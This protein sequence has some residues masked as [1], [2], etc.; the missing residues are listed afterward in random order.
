[1]I[2]SLALTL[3]ACLVSPAAAQTTGIPF[4]NDLTINGSVSG[5]TS[6]TF[7]PFT[8]PNV[9]NFAVST[10]GP[11]NNVFILFS[12]GPCTPA[13]V[14]LPTCQGTTF[15]L[16]PAFPLVVGFAGPTGGGGF[17]TAPL[18]LPA[19]PPLR[20]ATQAI[21]QDPSC[22]GL[23]LFTQAYQISLL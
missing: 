15:D 20:F 3:V 9:L 16:S 4:F 13:S 5:S 1:M 17:F 22:G 10:S 2:R 18:T 11:G 6:C 8:T 19:L 14:P 12:A 23:L 21:I 7:L